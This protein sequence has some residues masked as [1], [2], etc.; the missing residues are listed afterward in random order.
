MIDILREFQAIIGTLLGV[1]LTLITTHFLRSTGRVTVRLKTHQLDLSKQDDIGGF[2]PVYSYK[3]TENA[4]LNLVVEFYNSSETMK[5]IDDIKLE[6]LDNKKKSYFSTKLKD[7]ETAK[8]LGGGIQMDEITHLNLEPKR[9]V[10]KD[11]SQ[12]FT[13]ENILLLQQ[14][15]YLAISY[16]K[17]KL[18]GK[19]SRKISIDFKF[20]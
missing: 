16:K 3:N 13:R 2:E 17:R 20:N 15:E 5:T 11:L 9:L 4:R 10:V 6:F 8:R 18:N 7:S 1:F 12:R 14:S 19:L